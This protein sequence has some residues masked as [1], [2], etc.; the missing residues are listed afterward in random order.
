MN[1]ITQKA[2][3]SK[4]DLTHEISTREEAV[5]LYR[6]T[7]DISFVCHRYRISKALRMRWN[8][9]YDGTGDSLVS[10]SH[11]PHCRVSRK[12]FLYA[13][14]EQS[15]YSTVDFVKKALAFFGYAPE[16]IQTDHDGEFTHTKKTKR[17]QAFDRLCSELH[18]TPKTIRPKTPW[19]NGKVERTH[20]NAPKRFYNYLRFYSYKDLQLQIKRYLRCSNRIPMA[21]PVSKSPNQIQ[22]QL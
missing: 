15:S 8:Q 18:I 20:R 16:T 1:M 17:I 14:K 12:C 22:L 5:K 2:Q 4:R 19:H 6:Q 3:K 9:R 13:Y 10:R 11:R 21:V 7:H